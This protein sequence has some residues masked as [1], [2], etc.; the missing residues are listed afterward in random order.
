[1]ARQQIP[2]HTYGGLDLSKSPDEIGLEGAIDCANVDFVPSETVGTRP[3]LTKF[4]F[5]SPPE[6]VTIMAPFY[7]STAAPQLLVGLENGDMSVLSEAGAT[8]A[9]QATVGEVCSFVRFGTPSAER[10]YVGHYST[11]TIRRWDGTAFA[12]PAGQPAARHVGRTPWDNRLIAAGYQSAATGPGGGVSSPSTI[13]FSNKGNPEVWDQ[14]GLGGLPMLHLT[15]GDGEEISAVV[16]WR[17]QVFVFKQTKF[18]RFYGTS[19]N[20][21]TAGPEFD[22]T[23]VDTGVGCHARVGQGAVGAPDGVYFIGLDGIYRTTGGPPQKVSSALDP[24]FRGED[25]PYFSGRDGN[26]DLA[27]YSRMHYAKERL[28]CVLRSDSNY[29][30]WIY[31]IPLDRWSYWETG[32]GMFYSA[33]SLIING[34]QTVLLSCTLHGNHIYKLDPSATADGEEPIVSHYRSGFY[35]IGLDIEKRIQ[36][37]NLWGTGS[38]TMKGSRDFGGLD[39][40]TAATL[41]STVPARKY[42]ASKSKDGTVFSH[43]FSATSG[44]WRIHR[45]AL[46]LETPRQPGTD[47]P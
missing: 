4:G 19:P 11:D 15:P 17:D 31:D 8:L 39:T 12:S 18:F 34:E 27:D 2:N 6:E 30:I 46:D 14:D 20:P 1:M 47:T 38:V 21:D 43:Q 3:G 45:C 33:G 22:Y 9:N 26:P 32:L 35:D 25:L 41:G 28:Y 29:V 44:R 36:G 37:A 24:W 42:V 16:G 40:G 13:Y 7:R 23:T 5:F 10:M